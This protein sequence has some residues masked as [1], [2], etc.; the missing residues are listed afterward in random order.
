[1]NRATTAVAFI[2]SMLVLPAF[3]A[4]PDAKAPKPCKE[5]EPGSDRAPIISPPLSN[6]VI[7]TGRLQF[8]SAP[9]FQCRLDGVFVIPRDV[10]ISYV[11]T[12][13]GWT[14]VS[15]FGPKGGAV[16]GWVRSSRLKATGT[17]APDHYEKE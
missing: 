12:D 13:D 6:D 4:Q 11:A 1:M 2:V 8:F 9:N 5:P 10:L 7:G 15:Y 14:S 17:I 16:S 3:A